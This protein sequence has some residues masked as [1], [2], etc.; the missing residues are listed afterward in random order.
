VREN[1]TATS[2]PN[3][4][5][6]T[7]RDFGWINDCLLELLRRV[8]RGSDL[9]KSEDFTVVDEDFEIDDER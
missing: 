3:R 4:T 5:G 8:C 1:Q 2:R 6:C 9:S 7:N